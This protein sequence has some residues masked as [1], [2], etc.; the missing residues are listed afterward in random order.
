MPFRLR[1]RPAAPISLRRGGGAWPMG[2][3]VA[4]RNGRERG[5]GGARPAK[6]P[7]TSIFGTC[8]FPFNCGEDVPRD[9]LGPQPC[10]LRQRGAPPRTSQD[11]FVPNYGA[12]KVAPRRRGG[13]HR[14]GGRRLFRIRNRCQKR[15]KNFSFFRARGEQT[16]VLA[17]RANFDS[18]SAIWWRGGPPKQRP[19]P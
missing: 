11:F 16:I 15:G 9:L 2:R 1:P 6:E 19:P 8:F 14:T 13:G 4:P 5:G 7:C 17:H 12:N 18:E 3:Y 10:Y